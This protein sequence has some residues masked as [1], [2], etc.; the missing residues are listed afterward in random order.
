MKTK[1]LT[2]AEVQLLAWF[3]LRPMQKVSAAEL[4][5]DSEAIWG[6]VLQDGPRV[7]RSLWEH[8]LLE[9]KNGTTAPYWYVGQRSHAKVAT[10]RQQ[11]L[12]AQ[13]IRATRSR[14]LALETFVEQPNVMSESKARDLKKL[15]IS[16]LEKLKAFE[17]G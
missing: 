11:A 6:R 3:K 7:A 9:R 2:P 5:D 14:I 12:F 17:A 16:M 1:K 4:R 15:C 10:Q 8:G 13:T